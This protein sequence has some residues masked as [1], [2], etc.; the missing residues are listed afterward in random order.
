MTVDARKLALFRIAF[1]LVLVMDLVSQALSLTTFYC[2]AGV[3]P[4]EA[5]AAWSVFDLTGQASGVGV[6][7]AIGIVAAVGFTLGLYTRASTF[8]LWIV[9]VSLAHR[10]PEI[11]NGGDALAAVLLLFC[12]FSE[13]GEL[14]SL[15]ARRGRACRHVSTIAPQ[16]LGAV[17]ALL[18]T[19]TA[20]Q[21]LASSGRDWIDGT[22]LFEDLHLA[23]WARPA[24]VWLGEHRGLCAA[25]GAATIAVELAIPILLVIAARRPRARALAIVVIV[26]HV[27]LQLGILITFKVGVFTNV[28]LAATALWLP[29]SWLDRVWARDPEHRIR[30]RGQRAADGAVAAAFAAAAIALFIN[31]PADPAIRSLGLDLDAS[32]FTRAYASVEW[33]ATG[34]LDTGASVDPLA[35]AAADAK[36][37][38]GWWNDL[39]MQ[40]PYRMLHYDP[41][42]RFVCTR[43]PNHALRHWTLRRTVRAHAGAEPVQTVV[44][45]YGCP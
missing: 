30:T 6:L 27:G 1:G 24:G 28:M 20:V 32:L 9:V 12:L 34:V 14:A 26:G 11:H 22:V 21:K 7:F 29:S 4:R 13:P 39:W 15:D 18:Y 38:D 42:G 23:G 8:V 3:F 35:I 37:D 43:Y 41:L 2:D 19:A 25:F 33:E 10:V 16:L 17:P 40:L 45:D 44:L 36:L 31:T 5:E